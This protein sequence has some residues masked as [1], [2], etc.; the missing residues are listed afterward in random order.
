MTKWL[1]KLSP[2]VFLRVCGF[3]ILSAVLCGCGSVP[4]PD[5][6]VVQGNGHCTPSADL[7]SHKTMKKVSV[8]DTF[9]DELGEL[10]FNERADHAKDISDYNSLYKTCVAVDQAVTKIETT[11][12]VK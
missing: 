6:I 10:L 9:M 1:Y 3:C 4:T 2:K 5:P 11:P 7:P 8:I 12:T